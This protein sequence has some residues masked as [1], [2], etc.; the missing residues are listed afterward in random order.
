MRLERN[1]FSVATGIGKTP[2]GGFSSGTD[3]FALFHRWIPVQCSG[4]ERPSCDGGYV[5]DTGLG[6]YLGA[7]DDLALQCDLESDIGC[8]RVPGGGLCVDHE[9]PLYADTAWGRTHS[10]LLEDE[11]GN[12]DR[13]QPGRFVT[14]AFRTLRFRN[15]A[16]LT[17]ADF[18]P[19]RK[20]GQGNVYTPARH[21]GTD[22]EKVFVWGRPAFGAP[23][24]RGGNAK[25]YFMYMDMP[26]YSETGDIALAMHYFT[27]L[28]DGAPQFS[29]REIDATPLD[30]SHPGSDPTRERWDLV[31]QMSISWLPTLKKWVMFY[32]GDLPV[33]AEPLIVGSDARLARDPEQAIH[34]RFADQPWGPWSAPEQALRGVTTPDSPA[35]IP[36]AEFGILRTPGCDAEHCPPHEAAHPNDEI[37]VLY[38][39]NIIQAWTQQAD[40]GA[41]DLY[42]TVSTW[43]PYQ[44]VLLKTR[45]ESQ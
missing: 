32:G 11:F 24:A 3:I 22:R 44:V 40:T 31:G 26:E 25:L 37:G 42:W 7:V 34:V 28:E 8:A 9:S 19:A 17:V 45:I 13:N 4:G 21:E 2:T 20:H 5:C 29:R 23:A 39:A 35:S 15:P 27:G 16:I 38:A 10:V 14:R 1:G 6:T 12:Q 18:D 33:R 36:S 41:V 30:L 43:D